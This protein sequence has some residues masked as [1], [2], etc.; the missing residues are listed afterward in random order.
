MVLIR[1]K[2]PADK[3]QYIYMNSYSD[4]IRVDRN[5]ADLAFNNK[6]I[7]ISILDHLCLERKCLAV[8]EYQDKFWLMSWD[9]GHLTEA[10][11]AILYNKISANLSN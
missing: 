8:A 3:N 10:G 1:N 5:L 11:S 4:L 2:V 7:F 9:F 6:I